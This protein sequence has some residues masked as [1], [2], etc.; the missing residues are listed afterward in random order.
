M[1]RRI[2]RIICLEPESV[3]SDALKPIVCL[4][5]CSRQGELLVGH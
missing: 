4:L 2:E 3:R 1:L 5:R